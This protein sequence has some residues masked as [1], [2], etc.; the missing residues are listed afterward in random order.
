MDVIRLIEFLEKI[1][2]QGFLIELQKKKVLSINE[3]QKLTRKHQDFPIKDILS[4]IKIQKKNLKKNPDS[5]KLIYTEKGAQQSSSKLLAEY[6]AQKFQEYSSL[7]DLCCGNGI[8]LMHLAIGK[9]KVYAIDLDETTLKTAKYNTKNF[10]NIE[11]IYGNAEDF[12]GQVEAIFVD[13]DRRT[14]TGRILD[15]EEMSPSLSKLLRL[16]SITLNIAIKLSPAAD[17]ES[18]KL[19]AEH[20]FEFISENRVLKEILLCFG[21]LSTPG[22]TR[23]AILLPEGIEL[24]T[25]NASIPVSGICNYLFEPD[26]AIIRAGLVQEIGAEIGYDLIDLHLALLSGKE[27]VFSKFGTTYKRVINFSYDLKKLHKYCCENQIGELIIKTR[28]FP[29]PVE[30]F[31]QKIKLKG[32]R[33]AILF[34]IR[35][36]DNHEMIIADIVS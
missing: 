16:K 11:F 30:K 33:K 17:Y 35:L 9:K 2:N 8:D 29:I 3:I 13:P 27:V 22:V 5:L 10:T 24:S 20:T 31:R 36:G 18:L 25:S 12:E 15:V 34:I 1:E 14:E 6:H 23:K 19:S 21:K 4:L 28:G 32:N 26:P 7:A